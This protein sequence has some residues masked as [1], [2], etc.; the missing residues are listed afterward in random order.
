MLLNQQRAAACMKKHGLDALIATNPNHVTYASN[1]GGHS[2]RIYPDRMVH[3][4]LPLDMRAALLAPIGDASYLAENSASLWVPE[5]WTYG[6]SKITWPA[7]L[8]PDADER[9]LIAIIQDKDHNTKSLP[10]LIARVLESRGLGGAVVGLDESGLTVEMHAKVLKAC[11]SVT[12]R[13]AAEIWRE[14]ELIKTD[15]ELD[16]LRKGALANQAA[17]DAV[18]GRVRAGVSEAE[19]MQ[20]YNTEV[21]RLGGTLEFWNSAGGRRGG[22][23]FPSGSYRLRKGDLYRYDAGMVLDHYHA[24]TGGVCV[25]GE[26]TKRQQELYAAITAGMEAALAVVR[27]GT[28]YEEVWRA[29]VNAVRDRGIANYDT[30]RPDLGHG[31]GI[32]PRAPG[33]SKGNLLPLEAGMIINVEVPYYEIGYGGFQTEYTLF[34]TPTGYEFL[35][36]GKRGLI[37]VET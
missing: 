30:L 21:T 1:Y 2:P 26:P 13:P 5:I 33:I 16:R 10:D 34:V 4:I 37:V 27:P 15:E 20:V 29:G 32:E 6:T 23:F 28:T 24:D 35:I 14:V 18:M 25:L 3:A 31:I 22:G 9:R 12:F 36:P 11:P 19:L 17:V 8:E 7:D